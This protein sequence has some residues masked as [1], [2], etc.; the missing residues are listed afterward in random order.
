MGQ[1]DGARADL[2]PT[3]GADMQIQT[4]ARATL[5]AVCLVG[6]SSEFESDQMKLRYH[7]P[8]GVKLV[9]EEAGPPRVVRFS[10]GLEIR[11]FDAKP[12]A[13]EEDKLEAL[14]QVVSPGAAGAVISA[15]L[16]SIDAGKVVRWTLKEEGKRTLVYF[17]PRPNRY[18]VISMTASESHYADLENQLELSL[19]SLKV[20]D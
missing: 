15:R 4:V 5:L 12:P 2:S 18:L 17:L 13:I 19:S 20:H 7:P 9:G 16:G 1:L 10:S 6:C 14:V 8:H 3:S 11:S